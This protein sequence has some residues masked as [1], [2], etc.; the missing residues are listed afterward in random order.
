M[1]K[2]REPMFCAAAGEKGVGKTYQT[3]NGVIEKYIKGVP[4]KGIPAKKCLIVDVN[5]EYAPYKLLGADKDSIQKFMY[6]RNVEARRIGVYNRDGSTK[7][8]GQISD[9]FGII[10]ETF[11]GGLLAVEDPA[12]IFGDSMSM[13]IYG[14]LCTNRH[15]DCDIYTH[16]QGIGKIGH[17]KI[18]ATVNLLRL[19]HVKDSVLRH[20]NKFEED[21]EIVRIAQLLVNQR[22]DAGDFR[23]FL[24]VNFDNNKISGL[25][26]KAE[27]EQAVYDYI[28]ENE[29]ETV[30][31]IA[32]KRDP[33]NG[34]I[35]Y[36]YPQALQ[37]AKDNLMKQYYGNGIGK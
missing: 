24:Y 14:S 32:K 36:N 19:H 12:K 9:E 18:K 1:Q 3:K 27:F 8:T 28:S 10:L 6:Q 2:E 34:K 16:Y 7:S 17:P 4:E 30:V 11:R 31:P 22:F 33:A 37:I 13:E 23:F 15:R 25:F 35:L 26:T 5:N 29:R 20:K 21:T